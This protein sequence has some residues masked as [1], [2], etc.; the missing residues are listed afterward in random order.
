ML[1]GLA[2]ASALLVEFISI[3]IFGRPVMELVWRLEQDPTPLFEIQADMPTSLRYSVQATLT[4]G[5]YLTRFMVLSLID[6][7]AVISVRFPS[8]PAKVV[9][10]RA[11]RD[12]KTERMRARP[13]DGNGFDLELAN[14][15]RPKSL[16]TWAE[17][18]FE[19]AAPGLNGLTIDTIYKCSSS[20]FRHRFS[21][22]VL[23]VNSEVKIAKFR[24]V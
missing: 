21:A 18:R 2:I 11:P 16:W 13:N 17:V 14:T 5:S 9:V 23:R 10:D 4:G 12:P 1:A 24:S 19:T 22:K 8:S 20:G 15:T 3:L 6:S 7:D